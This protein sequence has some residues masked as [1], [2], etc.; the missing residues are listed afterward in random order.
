MV[1][2]VI[3]ANPLKYTLDILFLNYLKKKN[4][5]NVTWAENSLFTLILQS[6]E[7][8]YFFDAP[9]KS[10]VWIII[11]VN[12]GINSLVSKGSW[13]KRNYCIKV[14][15]WCIYFNPG[16]LLIIRYLNQWN[17]FCLLTLILSILNQIF[18]KE[19]NVA[20]YQYIKYSV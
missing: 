5:K 14:K 20:K 11:P 13:F 15:Y 3:L 6:L 4:L 18:L 12:R 8:S 1:F 17:F 7:I 19:E 9:A 2:K 10:A 16:C